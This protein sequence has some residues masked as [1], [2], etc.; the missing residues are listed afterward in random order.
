M[1]MTILPYVI[2]SLIVGLG[3]LDSALARQLAFVAAY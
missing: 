2:V 3:Q 1:Q